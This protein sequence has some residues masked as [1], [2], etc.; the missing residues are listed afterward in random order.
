MDHSR[1]LLDRI[2]SGNIRPVPRW[3]VR[4]RRAGLV[5]LFA[6]IVLMGTFSVTLAIQEI[7]AHAGRGW[8]FRRALADYAP[9]VWSL[10]AVL[11]VGVGIRVFRELPRGWRVRPWHVGASLAV[12]CMLGGW[13]LER[14]EA[15]LA[16]HRAVAMRIPSYREVWMKKALASW[17]DPRGGRISGIWVGH[18]D[19][20]GILVSQDGVRW[21][22]HWEGGDP[23]PGTPTIR[24]LGSVCGPSRFCATEWR[25]APGSGSGDFRRGR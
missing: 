15:L 6:A 11:L 25:P 13:S 4:L 20:V 1:E 16:L 12:V 22:V 3:W 8:L 24:L 9:Y 10:T 19:T 14:T 21:I 2:H 18:V 23:L 5:A 7:H 17:H